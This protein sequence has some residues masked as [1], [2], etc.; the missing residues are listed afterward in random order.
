MD[1][2]HLGPY[3][4][5]RELGRGGMG[6][7]YAA[8]DG[9]TGKRVAVKVL[10]PLL[11]N[12]EGF[13]ERF[14]SEIESLQQ[15]DHPNIVK[16]FG[17]GEQASNLYYAMELIEGCSLEEELMG[18]RKF[19][20][21]E[22]CH[23][24]IDLCRALKLAHDNGIV[25]RDIKP[26]NLLWSKDGQIKLSD[27]GIARLFGNTGLTSEGG[28]LGTAEYMAPEQ[29]DGQRATH[30]CDL[31]SLG[32]VMY[33]LLA[34][35]PPFQSKSMLKLLQ[36]QRYSHPESVLQY[37]PDTPVEMVS[38]IMQLLEKDPAD[39]L[40]NA[41]L[42]ARQLEAME[43]G[44]SLRSERHQAAALSNTSSFE[45][46]P[47]DAQD[48]E[49]EVAD[50]LD[51]SEIK[52]QSL[53]TGLQDASGK[54]SA[55]ESADN[56]SDGTK[57]TEEPKPD[58]FTTIE[59]AREQEERS[60]KTTHPLISAPTWLLAA[61]LLLTAVGIWYLLQ[62]PTANRLYDQIES[63]EEEDR[64]LEAAEDI[65]YFLK[66]YHDDPRAALVGRYQ[67]QVQSMQLERRAKLQARRLNKRYPESLIG[68]EYLAAIELADTEPEKA[69]LKLRAIVELYDNSKQ[70][71]A[72]E[73]FIAAAKQQ[74]PRIEQ[75]SKER[76][77]TELRLLETRL[78]AAREALPD[79]PAKARAICHAIVTL[80]AD[81][82][83][84]EPIVVQAR[85]ILDK[86]SRA[87]GP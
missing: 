9:T 13:R 56:L 86:L 26:A 30:L 60:K 41:L 28:V 1:L 76:A 40:P 37:A 10:A 78:R 39:R 63:A 53:E 25:H 59:E 73:K 68:S 19:Q 47:F 55:K 2:K 32:V 87:A 48:P 71:P 74:L 49:N 31:Y 42:V 66:L 79:N 46:N 24:A 34:G 77:K 4:I 84:A 6:T 70:E 16:L 83:W 7:V 11:A 50:T 45:I 58:R 35:R 67:E 75:D 80:Y 51:I 33:A 54:M 72:I 22:V 69:A 23:I 3:Q 14:E 65:S 82:P 44:L 38:I 17:F 27:F 64:L 81:K 36:M 12:Q 62:P 43:R 18:G 61:A 57:Q 8:V 29:A 5:D 21:R 52:N 15:L 85:E 20:W